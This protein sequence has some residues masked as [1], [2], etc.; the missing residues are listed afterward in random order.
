MIARHREISEEAIPTVEQDLGWPSQPSKSDDDG[1]VR[2][3]QQ[4]WQRRK[5]NAAW[6]DWVAIGRALSVGRR[7]AMAAA[8]T[9]RPEGSCYNREFGIWLERNGFADIDK[10]DRNRLFKVLDKLPE[11]EEWRRTL[12]RT[13]LLR[14]NHPNTV[15]R[16]WETTTRGP[17]AKSIKPTLRDRVATLK[18]ANAALEARVEEAEAARDAVPPAPKG[19]DGLFGA[20]LKLSERFPSPASILGQLEAIDATQLTE[21]ADWLAKVAEAAKVA[22]AEPRR[23]IR[24]A[25]HL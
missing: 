25:G 24:V 2:L 21:L 12:P 10:G 15:L 6:L 5:T 20:L 4:A 1:V 23:R 17:K 7:A 8:A 22:K 3:G 11:I 14:L 13:Q 16:K 18:E 19:L 9:D